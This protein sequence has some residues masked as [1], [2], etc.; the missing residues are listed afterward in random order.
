MLLK[1]PVTV[2]Q[3]LINTYLASAPAIPLLGNYSKK[4]KWMLN[5]QLHSEL[6]AVGTNLDVIY[7][8]FD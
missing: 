3:F 2:W 6:P 8:Q 5:P 7:Y 1:A 4:E